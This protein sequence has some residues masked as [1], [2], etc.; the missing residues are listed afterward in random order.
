MT[1]AVIV[2]AE[3]GEQKT[4]PLTAAEQRQRDK[5]A[6]DATARDDAQSRAQADRTALAEKA[7][8]GT[9]TPAETQ[10]ALALLLA[11]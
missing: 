1:E 4:R 3:T 9:L 8:A 7:K 5:D 2:N 10:R 6:A 11:R